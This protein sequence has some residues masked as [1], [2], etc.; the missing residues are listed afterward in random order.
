VCRLQEMVRI[1]LWL[2]PV[3]G[4]CAG[5]SLA[6]E[7]G[8]PIGRG[9]TPWA[10]STDMVDRG[11]R[12]GEQGPWHVHFEAVP[13]PVLR[14]A[15]GMVAGVCEL[16]GAAPQAQRALDE[17]RETADAARRLE[18]ANELGE[19]ITN[20]EMA[21]N[22]L[23]RATDGAGPA[24]ASDLVWCAREALEGVARVSCMTGYSQAIRLLDVAIRR[25]F[26]GSKRSTRLVRRAWWL[27]VCANRRNGIAT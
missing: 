2:S 3:F 5:D 7:T 24:T 20:A 17:V 19:A 14:E 13:W 23:L 26:P 16:L 15:M 1:F 9:D 21:E 8:L 27:V 12:D 4:W 18:A 22:A 11:V 6:F 25:G 10:A